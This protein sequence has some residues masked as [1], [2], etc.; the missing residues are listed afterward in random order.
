MNEKNLGGEI[1][2]LSPLI[3]EDSARQKISVMEFFSDKEAGTYSI[4]Y[5]CSELNLSYTTLS[6][7]TQ[8]IHNNLLDLA[9][10]P[11]LTTNG[12][13]A[14][15]PK[16]YHHNEYIQYLVRTS[17]P[18]N[19]IL[20]SLTKP[21]VTFEEFCDDFYLSQSTIL[22]KL[23]PLKKYLDSFK[24]RLLAS[25]MKITGNE[26][27]IRMFYTT[28]LWA[29]NLGRDI[30]LSQFDFKEEREI[31]RTLHFDQADFMH[32]REIFLRLAVN[33][34]RAEQ[35]YPLEL[36]QFKTLPFS[37]FLPALTT[38]CE[39][40]IPDATQAYIQ[41]RFI[42]YMLY[43]TPFYINVDD[44]RIKE[45][46]NYYEELKERGS[47]L[48]DLIEEYE[49]FFF[50]ELVPKTH[51]DYEESFL[52]HINLFVTLTN[53]IIHQGDS[54]LIM[55]I[56]RHEHE[57]EH[58]AYQELLKRNNEFFRR[59]C[60]RKNFSWLTP[61]CDDLVEDITYNILPTFKNCYDHQML[62]VG[63]LNIPDYFIMQT[64][65]EVLKQFG[66]VQLFFTN[67]DDGNI[68]FFISTFK[69]LLPDNLEKPAFIVE[70]VENSNY[71]KEL[72][73]ALWQAYRQKVIRTSRNHDSILAQ[74]NLLEAENEK[75]LS[76]D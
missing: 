75:S 10:K 39:K 18:Y 40:F 60:R 15:E 3:L 43:F 63:I 56:T 65:K 69:E 29:G 16:D 52:L 7:L 46:N 1:M 61:C 41:G 30:H 25:K 5:L 48:I 58:E 59:I 62:N 20:Y 8:E 74:T 36:P 24:I 51:P 31:M 50:S 13:I 53:Y 38:Y 6:T 34:L 27:M 70:L 35:N 47:S 57:H 28:Y 44:F 2:L 21:E 42:S 66:F 68:D 19:F 33:R 22:R 55:D 45:L 26:A 11:F 32:P 17:I 14:W 12:K 23:R 64:V 49:L 73:A 76:E 54:P 71:E 67:F 37:E 4:N 9:K 72:F